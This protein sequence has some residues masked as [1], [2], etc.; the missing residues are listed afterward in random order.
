MPRNAHQQAEADAALH[1]AIPLVQFFVGGLVRRT[2]VG[3]QSATPTP[4]QDEA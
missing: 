3:R 2:D 4:P 1:L